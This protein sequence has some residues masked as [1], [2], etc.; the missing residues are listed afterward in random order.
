MLPNQYFG[1]GI[2]NF[3]MNLL[4]APRSESNKNLRFS[5]NYFVKFRKK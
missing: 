2:F 5:R 1:R 4:T 3:M